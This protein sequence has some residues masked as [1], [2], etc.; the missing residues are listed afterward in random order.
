MLVT[1][2][3]AHAPA[4]GLWL[5]DYWPGPVPK[6]FFGPR[7]NPAACRLDYIMLF[8]RFSTDRN[9]APCRVVGDNGRSWDTMISGELWREL[10]R[11]K[12]RAVSWLTIDGAIA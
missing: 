1:H 12:R 9:T 11:H 10:P 4:S 5:V 8:G 7:P 6:F 3:A 2:G